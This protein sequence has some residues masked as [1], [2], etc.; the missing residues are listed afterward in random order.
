MLDLVQR[1]GL[2]QPAH[3]D[4]VDAHTV[5][6]RVAVGVVVEVHPAREHHNEQGDDR[7]DDRPYAATTFH[8]GAHLVL[9]LGPAG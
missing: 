5:S 3:G 8:G 9:G 4:P 6:D 7:A 2:A 1:G